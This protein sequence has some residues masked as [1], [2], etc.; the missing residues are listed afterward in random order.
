MHKKILIIDEYGFSK[1]CAAIL[2]SIGYEVETFSIIN[3][4]IASKLN[5]YEFGLIITSYPY[6]AVYF[7]EIKNKSIPILVLTDN[8]DQTLLKWLND[9]NSSYCM[10]KPLDYQKFK[11]IIQRVL[12]GDINIHGYSIL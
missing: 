5:G 9:F 8:I 11:S 3:D 10:I 4:N 6:G 2:G 7:N 1:I 12:D